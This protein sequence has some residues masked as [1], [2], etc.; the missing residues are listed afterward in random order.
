MN[1]QSIEQVGED[2]NCRGN[3]EQEGSGEGEGMEVSAS[4]DREKEEEEERNKRQDDTVQEEQAK[5]GENER[6]R[7]LK[8]RDVQQELL[9]PVASVG[10]TASV[11][12]QE[13]PDD[14]TDSHTPAPENNT[15]KVLAS[16][17]KTQE[18]THAHPSPENTHL[19]GSCL[20][21]LKGEDTQT[22][23]FIKVKNQW[24]VLFIL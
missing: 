3:S 18:N 21:I 24:K 7:G 1:E 8:N 23:H 14:M 13:K 9:H 2:E 17:L 19:N 16:E 5:Q 15:D 6:N 22:S 10:A 4:K 12:R 20:Q 11:N